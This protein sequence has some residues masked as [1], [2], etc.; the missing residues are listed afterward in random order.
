[1]SDWFRLRLIINELNPIYQ[2]LRRIQFLTY[3]LY[4]GWIYQNLQKFGI[5]QTKIWMA[6]KIKYFQLVFLLLHLLSLIIAVKIV[7]LWKHSQVGFAYLSSRRQERHYFKLRT[8]I[9][10]R[11][12]AHQTTVR[13]MLIMFKDNRNKLVYAL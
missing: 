10:E 12:L 7:S 1:M 6:D 9:I 11:L 5:I 3:A 2:S 8:E 13:V 4:F